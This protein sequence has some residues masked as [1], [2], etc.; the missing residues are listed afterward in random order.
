MQMSERKSGDRK[1]PNKLSYAIHVLTDL[2]TKII[3][4]RLCPLKNIIEL[5]GYKADKCEMMGEQ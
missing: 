5:Y 2:N 1:R 4:S 3:I